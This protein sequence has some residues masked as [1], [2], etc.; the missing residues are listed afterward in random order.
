ME[1]DEEKSETREERFRRPLRTRSTVTMCDAVEFEKPFHQA[2]AL[3]SWQ[4]DLV[5]IR[6]RVLFFTW[7]NC[8]RKFNLVNCFLCFFSRCFS[9]ISFSLLTVFSLIIQIRSKLLFALLLLYD[10]ARVSYSFILNCMELCPIESFQ[11]IE[12]NA[13]TRR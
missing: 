4:I 13:P 6:C 11:L 12:N 3:R 7:E 2:C 5:W 8:K 10:R 9:F 1:S